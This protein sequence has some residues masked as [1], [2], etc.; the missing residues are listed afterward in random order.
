MLTLKNII[1]TLSFIIEQL[2]RT[3]LHCVLCGHITP[4]SGTLSLKYNR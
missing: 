1:S 2:M 3:A 4:L